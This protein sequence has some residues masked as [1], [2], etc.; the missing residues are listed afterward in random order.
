MVTKEL[1]PR[2]EGCTT[3]RTAGQ[4]LS[5]ALLHLRECGEIPWE[6]LT[7]ETRE[8]HGIRT[9]ATIAEYLDESVGR[10]SLDRWAGKPA[11]MI[12]CESRSLAG[13]LRATAGNLSIISAIT[14]ARINR[15][16]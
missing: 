2:K 16:A 15:L 11:P 3:V 10:A 8:M 7:D 4:N 13:A 12:I 14:L 6:W 1:P 5:D 9:A